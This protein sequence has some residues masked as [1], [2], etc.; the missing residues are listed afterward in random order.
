MYASGICQ[1]EYLGVKDSTNQLVDILWHWDLGVWEPIEREI[2]RARST[3]DRGKGLA[4]ALTVA[5]FNPVDRP[6][7][8]DCLSSLWLQTRLLGHEDKSVDRSS[9]TPEAEVEP[10]S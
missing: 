5:A 4:L 9:E 3:S 8:L 10:E 6:T 2:S 1:A 7:A